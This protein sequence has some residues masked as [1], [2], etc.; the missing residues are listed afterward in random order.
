MNYDKNLDGQMVLM[1][2]GAVVD[3]IIEEPKAPQK[4]LSSNDFIQLIC[5]RPQDAVQYICSSQNNLNPNKKGGS[6]IAYRPEVLFLRS[7]P[8][9]TIYENNIMDVLLAEMSTY[10]DLKVY[11]IPIR[12]LDE[13]LGY[14]KGSNNG[15]Q[16]LKKALPLLKEKV[17]MELN[18]STAD[19]MH[20]F[21]IPW[22]MILDE[23]IPNGSTSIKNHTFKFR[24]TPY[25]EAFVKAAGLLHGAY[26]STTWLSKLSS[27]YSRNMF[28]VAETFK[29]YKAYPTATPG[30]VEISLEELQL[31]LGYTSKYRVPDIT[32]L[33]DKAKRDIDAVPNIDVTFTY[34]KKKSG[35]STSGF[36][37][38]FVDITKQKKV[39]KRP[40]Q[41]K[42]E[43][44]PI[45]VDPF[46]TH[47]DLVDLLKD[48]GLTLPE[49][50]TIITVYESNNRTMM[51]VMRSIMNINA[52]KKPR[53]KFALL[54]YKLESGEFEYVQKD[55]PVKSAAKNKFHNF[56]ERDY[57]YDDLERKLLN[58]RKEA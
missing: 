54:K 11:E 15:Y 3:E 49:I 26:Y 38:R 29:N 19:G 20:I 16:V 14:A 48:F 28:Y 51:E 57:D 39:E 5:E 4:K 23:F 36:L 56:Q 40:E 7:R 31:Y 46:I 43:K 41:P 10:P 44:D 25:F 24:P 47:K 12:E 8:N 34:E 9:Y 18:I 27:E 58:R 45:E 6:S 30:I 13:R 52:M 35:R 55:A 37:F 22:F 32:R 21:R 50:R 2:S 33:L 1:P 42:Q 17:L 53:S